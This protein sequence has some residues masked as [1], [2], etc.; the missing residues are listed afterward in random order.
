MQLGTEGQEAG[1][2]GGVVCFLGV[3][4]VVLGDLV[5]NVVGRSCRVEG[6]SC[7]GAVLI[8]ALVG[9]ASR[10]FHRPAIRSRRFRCHE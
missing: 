6:G 8:V 5:V 9:A 3:L 1:V 2:Q 4:I 7:V 10:P